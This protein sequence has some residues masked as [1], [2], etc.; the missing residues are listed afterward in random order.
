MDNAMYY[1]YRNFANLPY[2]LDILVNQRLYAATFESLNDPM[3]GSYLYDTGLLTK[4]QIKALYEEKM[5]YRI[6]S[7]SRTMD[8]MLMWAYYADSDKGMV[9]GVDI[10]DPIVDIEPVNYVKSLKIPKGDGNLAKRILTRKLTAWDHEEEV[11]VLKRTDQF[12]KIS[13]KVVIFGS[14]VDKAVKEIVT[15]IA[16]R[17]C[18]G[19]AISTIVRGQ[20]KQG[21][22]G[23]N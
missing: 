22:K 23:A 20:L 4:G 14:A 5:S 12:V 17:F 15:S 7:L 13:V 1:K 11:R 18:P 2:A 19:V 3:E 8:N 10:D 21:A 9:V 16:E 6:L